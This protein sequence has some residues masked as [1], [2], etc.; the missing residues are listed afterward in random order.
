MSHIYI[1]AKHNH[2]NDSCLNYDSQRNRTRIARARTSRSRIDKDHLRL[3][4]RVYLLTMIIAISQAATSPSA[5]NQAPDYHNLTCSKIIEFDDQNLPEESMDDNLPITIFDDFDEF[6]HN[7]ERN[8]KK[9]KKLKF[10]FK[11]RNGNN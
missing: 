11:P 3:N 2:P 8:N 6:D 9:K 5:Q 7:F 10:N 1:N 4:S